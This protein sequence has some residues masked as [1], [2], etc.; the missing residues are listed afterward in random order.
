MVEVVRGGTGVAS[1]EGSADCTAENA[2][3]AAALGGSGG[4]LAVRCAGAVD[5]VIRGVAGLAD[6]GEVQLVQASE[7][8]T[9]LLFD[10]NDP[11]GQAETQVKLNNNSE[12]TQLAQVI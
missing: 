2:R 1:A 3:L 9:Q 6:S 11:T 7:Q 8:A 4:D 10:E 5:E 12:D